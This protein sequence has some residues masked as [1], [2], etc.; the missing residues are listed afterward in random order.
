MSN[1]TVEIFV[2]EYD[3]TPAR[4]VFGTTQ[5]QCSNPYCTNTIIQWDNEKVPER[6]KHWGGKLHRCAECTVNKDFR[7]W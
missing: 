7:E 1:E 3:W 5:T 4:E 6:Y 2:R